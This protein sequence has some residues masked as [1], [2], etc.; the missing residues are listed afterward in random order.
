MFV[1]IMLSSVEP[2]GFMCSF[3]EVHNLSYN[4]YI[5]YLFLHPQCL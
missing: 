2:F 3:H 4:I 1:G 5:L